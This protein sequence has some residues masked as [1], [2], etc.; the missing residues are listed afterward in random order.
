MNSTHRSL[1]VVASLCLAASAT[2][3]ANLTTT[4]ASEVKWLDTPFGVQ[5]SPV[6][7]DFQKGKHITFIKFKAGTSTPGH[8]HTHAYVGVVVKGQG[9]HYEPSV[10]KP[11]PLPPG[12][13][14]RVP[15]N[16]KHVSG[17]LKGEDCVFALYQD[18][19]FDYLEDKN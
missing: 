11:T 7:G 6:S 4:P 1:L 18:E 8:T 3:A 17:C 9:V 5:A 2:S 12:S 16:A 14:W 13:T 19:P 10:S 15:A